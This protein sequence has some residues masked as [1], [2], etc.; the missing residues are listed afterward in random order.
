MKSYQEFM[1]R[2]LT[3]KEKS[4][5]ERIVKGMKKNK[6]SFKSNYKDDAESVMYATATK[7]AKEEKKNCGCGKDPCITYGKQTKVQEHNDGSAKNC[8]KGEY[9]CKEDHKCKPI[10]KGHH[11]MKD[12]TLMKGEPHKEQITSYNQL[13]KKKNCGCGQTPCITYGKKDL[14]KE[15]AAWTKKSGKKESGG[16]NEKGRKSV[17]YT[18]LTLPTIYSV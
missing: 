2:S 7:L 15:G 5:K 14:T 9:F 11:V 10:P 16:L 18:H 1:E 8:K 3:T 17:S 6:S 4:E 12:G 13:D